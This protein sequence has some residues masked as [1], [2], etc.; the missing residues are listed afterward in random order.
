MFRSPDT[1]GHRG[2]VVELPVSKSIDIQAAEWLAKLDGDS[3]DA[4]D[5]RAFKLW[6]GEDP[7]NR[8]AFEGMIEIWGEMNILTQTLLPS[9]VSVPQ[10]MLESRQGLSRRPARGHAAVLAA[11]VV[12]LVLAVKFFG[13]FDVPAPAPVTYATS[14]GEQKTV[15]LP[16][17]ST[18]LLNTNTRLEVSYTDRRRRLSLMRG[19]AHFEVV[20]NSQRPFEVSAGKGLVRALGTA[21][22]VHIRKVDIEVIVTE[23]IIELDRAEMPD[24]ELVNM[25]GKPASAQLSVGSSKVAATELA[26]P[27]TVGIEIKAGQKFVYDREVL[28][29]VKLIVADKIEEEL[30]WRQGMLVFKSEPLEKVVEEVSRYTSLKIVIPQRDA[31]ELLVGGIFSVGDTESLFEALRESFD[32]NVELAPDGVVYL[33]SGDKR[34][35]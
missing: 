7:A 16:D 23:G 10:S 18:V 13:V 4:D 3:P 6:I 22:T 35:R 19:E 12:G 34:D 24:G 17:G 33:I 9:A 14:V 25:T 1:T 8:R 11:V 27:F 30:S 26:V 32:I 20:H 31:R 2:S 29:M 21:F 5:L 28:D 15:T